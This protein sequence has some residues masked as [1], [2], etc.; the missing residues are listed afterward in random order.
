VG[1]HNSHQSVYFEDGPAHVQLIHRCSNPQKFRSQI[2]F[3]PPLDV[4]G[5]SCCRPAGARSP[6]A[7]LPPARRH[8]GRGA[9]NE[10]CITE[11]G[12]RVSRPEF[13][14]WMARADSGKAAGE[15]MAE[16]PSAIIY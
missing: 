11:P 6:I 14:A 16:V 15:R 3:R 10:I 7:L 8:P 9:A 4:F 12:V 13:G 2:F 1:D 5:Q